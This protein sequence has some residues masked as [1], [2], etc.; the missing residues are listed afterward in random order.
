MEAKDKARE[1]SSGQAPKALQSTSPGENETGGPAEPRANR[2]DRDSPDAA[3]PNQLRAA[4]IEQIYGQASTALHAALITT[5]LLCIALWGVVSHARLLMWGSG[6]LAVYLVRH[7]MVLRFRRISPVGEATMPWGKWFAV[8][9]AVSGLMWGAVALFLFPDESV[10]HQALLIILIGGLSSGTVVVYST[11]KTA[12]VPYVL[13]AGLP[14]AGRF[15]YQGTDL[16]TMVGVIILVYVGFLLET[17]NR[18]HTTTRRYL[19]LRFEKDGLIDRLSGQKAEAESF[20]QTLRTEIVER[21]RAEDALKEARANL[22][23]KVKERTAELQES[24][25]KY[26]SIIESI[27]E[28]YYELDLDGNLLFLNDSGRKM[29]GYEADEFI[30]KSF[31]LHMPKEDADRAFDLYNRVFKTGRS[32]NATDLKMISSD[33]THRDLEISVACTVDSQGKAVGFRGIARD[34]TVRK[35]EQKEL[36][37][38]EKL[39]SIGVLAGGIAHDFNNIL[40]AI[41]G[42]ISFAKIL[43]D[44]GRVRQRLEEA[45]RAGL[46]ARDLTQQLLTFS[47]GGAPIRKA[48]AITEIISD[49]CNF[50]L[51]GS[52]VRCDLLIPEDVWNVDVDA[53]QINQV[54]HNVILNAGQA[55]PE[56]GSVRVTCQNICVSKVDGLPISD[57]LYVKIT[58]MDHGLGISKEHIPRIFDP[59]FSTKQAGSGLGLS[60]SYSIVTNHGGL[61]TV[62]SELGRGSAFGIYLPAVANESP[63][64]TDSCP[65]AIPGKGRILVMDD[66]EQIRNLVGELL[67]ELGYDVVLAQDGSEALDSYVKAKESSRPFDAV[68]L[69]LTVPGG[70]GGRETIR[71][72]LDYDPD[73]SAIVSSGYSTDPIM[74]DHERYGFRE[75]LPKPYNGRVLSTVLSRV[76]RKADSQTEGSGLSS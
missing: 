13:L 73:V 76:I 74:S 72:L 70:M 21:Q 8:S 10:L 47:K 35:R 12:Y 59:Y 50:V 37:K 20:N 1:C 56:G 68:I 7:G 19:T 67:E 4:Q 69:D 32:L 44:A 24:E 14:L 75:V 6:S 29:L 60:T 17:G 48:A 38:M 30:G 51:R 33:G 18:L 9:S 64:E 54:I 45:E 5:L 2:D 31:R 58:V 52:N 36:L 41:Q 28:A 25:A 40:T 63:F 11:L 71:N 27:G 43:S 66:E 16:H 49:S 62:E 46:R 61:I 55:M 53:G 34:L 3:K 65:A 57:G 23:Q 42:N 15:F 22:E 39:A 26:R